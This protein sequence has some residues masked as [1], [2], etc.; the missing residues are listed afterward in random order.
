MRLFATG[1]LVVGDGPGPARRRGD[2]GQD[3]HQGHRAGADHRRA[4]QRRDPQERAEVRRGDERAAQGDLPAPRSDPRRRRPEDRGDGVPGRGGQCADRD[5]LRQRRHRRMG[6]RR[7]GPGVEDVL[8]ERHHRSS[9]REVPRDRRDV[10][11]RDDRCICVLREARGRADAAGH[12]RR[13]ATGDAAH[14]RPAVARAPRGDGLPAGGHQPPRRR[15][16]GPARRMAARGL[17]DV[18]QPDEGHRPGLRQVR[19]A[20]PG[21]PQRRARTD[22]PERPADVQRDSATR[23]LRCGRAGRR[24]VG[25]DRSGRCRSSAPRHL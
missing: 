19:H 13:R 6:S 17:R 2:R 16:E 7:A 22:S 14:H 8:A 12:A 15:A 10:R 20:R 23:P 24:S 5:A 11:P 4:A 18:R 3:G 21:H 9:A 25:R 1:A